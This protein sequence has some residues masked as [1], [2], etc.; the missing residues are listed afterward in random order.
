MRGCV[1]GMLLRALHRVVLVRESGGDWTV[2]DVTVASGTA[3]PDALSATNLPS[4]VLLTRPA[5]LPGPAASVLNDLPVD[6]A[7]IV[8]G[9]AS[10]S[11][12]VEKRVGEIIDKWKLHG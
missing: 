6:S 10:V 9:H 5:A 12:G 4:P 11:P 8:G 7:R 3:F 1:A 2:R